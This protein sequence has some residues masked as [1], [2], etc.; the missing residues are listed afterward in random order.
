MTANVLTDTQLRAWIKT[1]VPLARADGSG[2][3]FT[4]SAAGT[5]AWVLRYRFGGAPRELTLGRYPD[6]SL[7]EARKLARLHR[8]RIQQGED[9]TR[10]NSRMIT[11]LRHFLPWPPAQANSA[12][13]I[14]RWPVRD[15]VGWRPA[16][17]TPPTSCC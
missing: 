3:T 4:L 9:V 17:W 1:G 5:A 6:L 16:T 2:L 7:A 12:S 8:A 14:W 13:G 11:R 10:A 15:W